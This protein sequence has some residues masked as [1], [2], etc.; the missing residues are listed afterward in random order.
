[1]TD[2]YDFTSN[3]EFGLLDDG[4]ISLDP[5]TVIA[6]GTDKKGDFLWTKKIS[7]FR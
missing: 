5:N 2:P 7:L 1:M 3:A 4:I 6:V